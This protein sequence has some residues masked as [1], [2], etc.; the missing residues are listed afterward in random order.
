M[1]AEQD[2]LQVRNLTVGLSGEKQTEILS[3]L[4]FDL[5]AGQT[6][7]IIGEAGSGK[8][9]LAKALVRGLGE[10]LEIKSGRIL[11]RDQD[12]LTLPARD[13]NRIRGKEIGFIGANPTG[14]LDPTVPIGEQI[15]EKLRAV[16]PELGSQQ[17][18]ERVLEVLA[19]VRI[20]SPEIRFSEFPFQF[21]GGMM[22]RVMIVDALVTNPSFLVADNITQALDVTVAAQILRLIEELRDRFSTSIVFISSSLPVVK[23]V[24][25][26][27]LVLQEGRIVEQAKP[28]DLIARPSHPY[29]KSLLDRLPVIWGPDVEA[30]KSVKAAALLSIRAVSRTYRVPKKGSF[31]QFNEVKAVRGVTM[32][33]REGENF[34]IVG[35]SGC[36]KSTLTRLLAWLEAPDS[37]RIFFQ[38]KD[39]STLSKK[40]LVAMRRSFQLLLQD[41]YSSLPARMSVRRIIAEPLMIHGIA[42]KAEL[43]TKVLAAMDEVGLDRSLE[44]SLTVGLSAGQRQRINI[45]RALVLEPKLLILDETLSSL[46]QVEQSK[47][48]ELFDRLQKAHGFT[49]IFISHDMAL[50]RKV[51]HRVAVMY[52]GQ[53]VELAEN[54]TLFESPGHPYSRALLSAVPTLDAHPFR[55]E[56]HLL[57]GEPPSPVHIPRGCTFRSRCPAA[58]GKCAEQEPAIEAW[59]D[60]GQISCHLIS[61]GFAPGGK[62]DETEAR[63]RYA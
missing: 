58:L 60:D 51:C 61:D 27:V 19:A 54:K 23:S 9:V 38:G 3:G 53:V 7:G 36:G 37:G 59:S 39:L 57:E 20:P 52:L 30:P 34:G 26:E 35:E 10:A 29:S 5:K 21:S 22:Q 63:Q 62:R 25:D 44:N 24:A 45:A 33:I 50:V 6:L 18:K 43:R 31:G 16:Q 46:D 41:P 2:T 17:A 8:T 55:V 49:Y 48:L 56:D 1:T 42:S 47:L 15:V 40:Q 28:E 4:S 14:S 13:L 12:L 11:Y 32:D